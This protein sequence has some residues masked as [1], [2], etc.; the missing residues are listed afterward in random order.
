[1]DR[2]KVADE[3]ENHSLPT[4]YTADTVSLFRCSSADFLKP[5]PNKSDRVE[6]LPDVL[7]MPWHIEAMCDRE[8]IWG[9]LRMRAFSIL[10]HCINCIVC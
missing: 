3:C 8:L 7:T 10:S 4:V 1:M 2:G 6:M 5:L 9:L